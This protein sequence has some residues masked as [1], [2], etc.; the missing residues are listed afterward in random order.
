M[1]IGRWV[2]HLK[3]AQLAAGWQNLKEKSKPSQIN[4][5]ESLEKDLD[6]QYQ[7]SHSKNDPIDICSYIQMNQ[8]DP[9]FKVGSCL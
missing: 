4:D 3:Q 7:I 1:Q 8:D 5:D 9:A 6:I 2:Q